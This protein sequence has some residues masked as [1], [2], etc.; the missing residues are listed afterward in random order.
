MSPSGRNK[1][2]AIIDNQKIECNFETVNVRQKICTRY[3]AL[4]GNW[5]F[6]RRRHFRSSTPPSDLNRQ[7][8]IFHSRRKSRITCKRHTI[9]RNMYW[10][11]IG[12][13]GRSIIW[14]PHF[15][16]RTSPIFS[17]WGAL[18]AFESSLR[19]LL[20]NGNRWAKTVNE[21]LL[22]SKGKA[23]QISLSVKWL[24]S[25]CLI[26]LT[27]TTRKWLDFG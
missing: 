22:G 17:A 18:T 5:A 9:E 21:A 23:F 13:Q 4:I 10:T 19:K 15:W 3:Q 27:Q 7:I 25:S 1:H 24:Y 14:W 8:A 6:E 26:E 2:N 20:E 11:L 16:S 12:N